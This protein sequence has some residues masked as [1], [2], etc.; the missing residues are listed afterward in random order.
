MKQKIVS[1]LASLILSVLFINSTNAA[2]LVSYGDKFYD[3]TLRVYVPADANL[4]K[5]LEYPFAGSSGFV[6]LNDALGLIQQLN[7]QAYLGLSNWRL[8]T[9]SELSHLYHE[10]DI[11]WLYNNPDSGKPLTNLGSFYWAQD[12]RSFSFINGQEISFASHRFVLPVAT[13][14]IRF[15]RRYFPRNL[16]RRMPVYP[17]PKPYIYKP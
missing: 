14:R 9:I 7:A 2:P 13:L 10:D 6:V 11:V 5:S 12:E 17:Y 8:P 3:R 15:D 16:R 1:I 4:A